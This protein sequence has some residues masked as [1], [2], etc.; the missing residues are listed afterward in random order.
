MRDSLSVTQFE[1]MP[2][3]TMCSPPSSKERRRLGGAG[4]AYLLGE[5][6]IQIRVFSF[7]FFL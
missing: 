5:E 7:L 6:D 4:E 2:A 3:S 1:D